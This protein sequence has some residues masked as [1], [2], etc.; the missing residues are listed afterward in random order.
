MEVSTNDFSVLSACQK[1]RIFEFNL[2][3]HERLVY[4]FATVAARGNEWPS[5]QFQQTWRG[6]E[7]CW[8][9]SY[10]CSCFDVLGAAVTL[11]IAS[12]VES[13]FAAVDVWLLVSF[14]RL[15]CCVFCVSTLAFTPLMLLA[16]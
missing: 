8:R 4:M 11:V 2:S 10:C 3:F 6:G 13:P 15:C 7:R 16:V 5:G 9:A 14:F 12:F 1:E